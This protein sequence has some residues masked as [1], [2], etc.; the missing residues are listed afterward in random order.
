MFGQTHKALGS[1]ESKI[2]DTDKNQGKKGKKKILMNDDDDEQLQVV[3][4]PVAV[5]FPKFTKPICSVACGA[6]HALALTIDQ[7][8]YS[9]GSGNYGALGFG[10][11]DDV[12]MPRRL[13]I[14]DH[15]GQKYRISQIC[16]GKFHS[17]C[18][19]TRQ[20][21]F[22]WGQGSHGRLGHGEANEED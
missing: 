17:M 7:E 20:N 15:K 18:L 11:H 10:Y 16:C 21:I 4:S 13:D 5:K 2:E 8:M 6:D 19:T 12:N 14:I 22:T 1:F 3:K 9:W